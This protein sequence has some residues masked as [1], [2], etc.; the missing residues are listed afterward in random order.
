M[1]SKKHKTFCAVSNTFSANTEHKTV[2]LELSSDLSCPAFLAMHAT[3]R[4]L[5]Y[6]CH[7]I[8]QSMSH[9]QGYL[10]CPCLSIA[11]ATEDDLWV[12]CEIVIYWGKPWDFEVRPWDCDIESETVSLTA[13]SWELEGPKYSNMVKEP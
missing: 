13:K 9:N 7:I 1:E 5:F 2:A 12:W 8:L 3:I 6:Q 10:L 4:T 11:T